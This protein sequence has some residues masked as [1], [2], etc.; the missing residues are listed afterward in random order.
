MR[1][2][3]RYLPEYRKIRNEAPDFLTFCYTP[4]LCVEAAL[5]PLRRYHMDAAILFSDILVVADA[6][7]CRVAF[8]EGQGPVLESIRSAA[9]VAAL[10]IE[11]LEDHLQPVFEAV[12]LLAQAIPSE[13]ALIGF[14]GAPWT[15]AVYM[16]EGRGG[17]DCETARSWGYRSPDTF[18]GL[19]DLLVEATIAHLRRQIENGAEVVQLFDS[20]AGILAESQFRSWVIRPTAE[21]V[22]RLKADH[23][24]IKVIGFP[25]AAGV[26]YLQYVEETGVDGVSIDATVPLS[27]AAQ[28]LQGRCLVQGNLDN[29][30]LV[31]GGQVVEEETMRIVETLAEGPF[32]F[33]LGHGILPQTPPENVA[34][35]SEMIRDRKRLESLDR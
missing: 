14:A 29:Q 15:V 8:V 13:T 19:I 6:L 35:V 26:R 7:G 27:W 20:W 31:V 5:Q 30:A 11:R 10:S 33:N 17:T 2:A 23:P 28:G 32:I 22:R 21:I 3:G 1:Q 34:M 25:R 16:V 4:A 12:R 24:G 9:D 18:G